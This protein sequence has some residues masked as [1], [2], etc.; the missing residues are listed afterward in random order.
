MSARMVVD[1]GRIL[2]DTDVLRGRIAP[3]EYM[4]V[5]KNDAYGHGV[6]RV[7]AAAAA[8]E[9][10]AVAATVTATAAHKRSKSSSSLG[11]G[12][13]IRLLLRTVEH[14]VNWTDPSI[15]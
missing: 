13:A 4:L 10:A 14:V 5:V 8:R 6:D 9:A 7:V 12:I 2:A 1:L 3:A 15:T 11:V